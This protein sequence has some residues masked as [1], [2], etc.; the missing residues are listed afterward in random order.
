MR[1]IRT[2]C[3]MII[4]V[5]CFLSAGQTIKAAEKA[6]Q[7]VTIVELPQNLNFYL[8]PENEKGRGQIYSNQYKVQNAGKE[9]VTFSIEMSLSVLDAEASVAFCPEEWSDEP[10][11]RSIYMYVLFEGE[12]TEAKH[13]L[14]DPESSCK[15]SIVLEPAGEAGDTFYISFG[16][17]LSQSPEWKSGELAVNSLYHM[18][19]ASMGY[20]ASVEGEHI[21]IEDSGKNLTSGERAELYLV[22][23]EGY[24]L[25]AEIQV[26]MGG[27][28]TEAVYDAATGKV[29]LEKVSHDVT[30]Y[31]NGITRAILPDMN[32]MN[33]EE[34]VWSW[35]AE[36]GI[37][38][39]EYRFLYEEEV[40]KSGRIDVNEGIVSWEWSDGLENGEYRLFLKAIGDAIHCLN[41]EE[42]DCWI[43]VDKE[44]LQPSEEEEKDPSKED[45]KPEAVKPPAD[46]T[47]IQP[48]PDGTDQTETELPPD[49]SN[50]PET[51]EGGGGETGDGPP[52]DGS[53]EKQPGSSVGGNDGT[54]EET[55]PD[56]NNGTSEGTP[57]DGNDGTPGGTPPDGNDGTSEGTPS[58]EG[59]QE[60]AD[61]SPDGGDGTQE[62]MPSDGNSQT[63]SEQ[64]GGAETISSSGADGDAG[65]GN[66]GN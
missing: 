14:T 6:A 15:E 46:G 17:K 26:W 47:D 59:S 42:V 61:S 53:D 13:I 50:K 60:P 36:E 54:P 23:D 34:P 12:Q 38:A 33:P 22:P 43:T 18:S 31:A 8:D 10:E 49:G 44:K 5:F 66:S 51:P 48:K 39:Y 19:S 20:M 16:G 2:R 7:Q 30:I 65:G 37:Q 35:T 57:S 24:F 56:G 62:G 40:V 1:K 55:P 58:D 32:V 29:V 11:D 41:S 3:M 4:A 45:E 25:P 27:A 63:T 21:R 28:E 52:T 9:A 64:G